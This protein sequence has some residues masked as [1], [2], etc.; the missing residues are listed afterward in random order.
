MEL[1]DSNPEEKQKM[2]ARM[3]KW[4]ETL[5]PVVWDFE[6]GYQAG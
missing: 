4:R 5:R 2:L 1:T 3:S 6:Q